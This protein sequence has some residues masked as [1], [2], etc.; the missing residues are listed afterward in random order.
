MQIGTYDVARIGLGTNRLRDTAEHVTFLRSAV[1]AGVQLVDTAHLYTSGESERAVGNALSPV[2]DGCLVATKG[3][4]G[5]A[6]PDVLA[7]EIEESLKRLRTDRIGLYY[8]HRV[9][10]DVPLEDSLGAIRAYVDRGAIAHVGLSE[11]GVEQIERGRAVVPIAA[12]QNHYNLTE[13]KHEAVVDHC[14]AQGIAF[15]PFFPLHGLDRPGVDAIARRHG[16]TPAQVA[17]AWMLR[18]SPVMAPIPG[19]LSLAHV[20]EDLGALDVALTDE[21]VA[22]L[23]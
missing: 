8:L 16:A 3:G 22:A 6:R 10:A 15:V 23:R 11:V 7:A 12:V 18:R 19:T 21:D 17:L 1:E 9:D 5:G 14:E 20:R 13:R 2:P 4:Y